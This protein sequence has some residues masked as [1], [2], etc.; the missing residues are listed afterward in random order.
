MSTSFFRSY[1]TF[2]KSFFGTLSLQT[3]KQTNFVQRKSAL[4]GSLFLQS[5]VWTAFKQPLFTLQS[6]ASTAE[7]LD[8]S[9][10]LSP[11]AFHSRFTSQ[12]VAFLQTMLALA[13]HK[14]PHHCHLLLPLA[15]TFSAL[16]LLDSSQV[17]LPDSLKNQ[18]PGCG[19]A[20]PAAAAKIYFLL[21]WFTASYST[22]EIS[23]GKQADQNRGSDF[24]SQTSAGAL[25]ITDLGFWNVDF[26]SQ[27]TCQGSYFLLR[28]QSQTAVWIKEKSGQ[29]V[30]FDLDKFLKFAPD[31]QS[32]EMNIYLGRKQSLECRLICTKV[33]EE[34]ANQR[35]RRVREAARRR[36]QAV[37]KR[38]LRRQSWTMF[39]TN[40][41]KEKIATTSVEAIYSIRWQVELAFKLAKSEAGLDKNN[42]KRAERV[43]C[44]FYAK[45]IALVLF[46]ALVSAATEEKKESISGV[47]GWRVMKEKMWI[48]GRSMKK[49][50]AIEELKEMG[51]YLI[52]RAKR[53][54]K[55]KKPG[56]IE[57]VI[58][59]INEGKSRVLIKPTEYLK[60]RRKGEVINPTCFFRYSI[61]AVGQAPA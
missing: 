55:K 56:T 16:Y 30:R 18:F 21:D 8:P 5:L 48:Y 57:K 38:H 51:E 33:N 31:D 34:I 44:E 53:D 35:R 2:L 60:R 54:G 41:E 52:R 17:S 49:N 22:I 9:C 50:I 11:Q 29:I 25:W 37:T 39:V 32:F 36:G 3:A 4:S 40:A 59:A 46:G 23:P 24:L 10:K 26:L 14:H 45:L 1:H 15:S 58:K 13:L 7:H 12:S 19:G 27:I 42:S 47:R 61:S 28:L 43:M 20:A 6:L